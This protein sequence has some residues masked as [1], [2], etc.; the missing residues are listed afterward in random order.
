MIDIQVASDLHLE[1]NKVK[2]Y[3]DIITPTAPILVLAGDI[4]NLYEYEKLLDFLKWCCDNFVAVLYVPGNHEFYKVY[5]YPPQEKYELDFCLKRIEEQLPNLYILS[6]KCIQ[7]ND[8][9]FAGC[10]L[11]SHFTNKYL[12]K[13]IVRIHGFNKYIYN[14]E[15]FK[16]LKWIETLLKLNKKVVI[17]THYPPIHKKKSIKYDKF[18]SLYGNDLENLIKKNDHIP[19]WI[20]GHVHK[21]FDINLHNT[22]IVSN[23]LGKPRD[24]IT[25]FSKNFVISL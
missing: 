8:M 22:R 1:Y 10:T 9:Y 24:N 23:Q 20:C 15:H 12:P 21:N 3:K 16:D 6:R 5:N 7:I 17:I 25:D 18:K 14:K 11:W 4:G 13:F 2:D 19:V